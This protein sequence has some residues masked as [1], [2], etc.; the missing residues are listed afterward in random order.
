[1]DTIPATPAC[2]KAGPCSFIPTAL[3]LL[4]GKS[5]QTSTWDDALPAQVETEAVN[6]LQQGQCLIWMMFAWDTTYRCLEQ[7]VG[8]T[9]GALSCRWV[10]AVADGE[11]SN[12]SHLGFSFFLAQTSSDIKSCISQTDSTI[13]HNDFICQ[14]GKV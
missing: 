10:V 9:K 1:M 5:I 4:I 13:C 6:G 12:G 11:M 2:N 14:F 8:I 3:N 7:E